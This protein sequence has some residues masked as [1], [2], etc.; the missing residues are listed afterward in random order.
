MPLIPDGQCQSVKLPKDTDLIAGLREQQRPIEQQQAVLE[1]V[2]VLDY[3]E[4]IYR[5]ANCER[6]VNHADSFC[7]PSLFLPGRVQI[8]HCGIR[9]DDDT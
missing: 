7:F 2:V 6:T 5:T 4:L 9:K 1:L 3:P 8:Y